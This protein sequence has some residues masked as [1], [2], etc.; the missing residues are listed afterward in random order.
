MTVVLRKLRDL[1]RIVK[2]PAKDRSSASPS[3]A[4]STCWGPLFTHLHN[5]PGFARIRA[6]IRARVDA[7]ADAVWSR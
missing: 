1:G 2:G 3:P 4:S 6:Q 7:I 5:E